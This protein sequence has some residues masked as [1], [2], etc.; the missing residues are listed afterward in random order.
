[1]STA[2]THPDC[3]SYSFRCIPRGNG[4]VERS[5]GLDWF[6]CFKLQRILRVDTGSPRCCYFPYRYR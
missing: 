2:S 3:H 1:M 5:I 4:L 6:E